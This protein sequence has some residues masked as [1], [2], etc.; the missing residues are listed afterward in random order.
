MCDPL[1]VGE[2]LWAQVQAVVFALTD[3]AA[4][5][6]HPDEPAEW[7]RCTSCHED[8]AVLHHSVNGDVCDVCEEST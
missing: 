5:H 7:P 1:K 2:W 8:T 6:L 3:H 4:A